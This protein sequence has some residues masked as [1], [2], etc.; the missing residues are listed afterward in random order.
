[1]MRP[2]ARRGYG[3]H[4]SQV[5]SDRPDWQWSG[6]LCFDFSAN[7]TYTA[8]I[9]SQCKYE[10]TS[11]PGRVRGTAQDGEGALVPESPVQSGSRTL[12]KR[13]CLLLSTLSNGGSYE[14][15]A[16]SDLDAET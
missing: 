7:Q 15:R 9:Y 16:R 11:Q 4:L 14:N 13:G 10:S 5:R 12:S 3:R 8:G 2:D 1:M 6:R